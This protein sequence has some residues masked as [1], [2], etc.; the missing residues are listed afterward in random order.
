M[1][2]GLEDRLME[3]SNEDVVHVAELVVFLIFHASNTHFHH[4]HVYLD[5]ERRRQCQVG[6]HEEL[7]GYGT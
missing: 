3:G 4:C 1:I 7:E 6:R 5:A 2:P